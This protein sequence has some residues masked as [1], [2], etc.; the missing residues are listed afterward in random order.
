MNAQMQQGG[1]T[2]VKCFTC[3]HLGR[4]EFFEAKDDPNVTITDKSDGVEFRVLVFICPVCTGHY[5][6]ALFPNEVN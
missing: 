5:T 3:G 6:E 2:H 1:F 4:I